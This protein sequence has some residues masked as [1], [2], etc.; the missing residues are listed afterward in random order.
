MAPVDPA[1]AYLISA[2][3][4]VVLL[5]VISIFCGSK[6]GKN[7]KA[8]DQPV[9]AAAARPRPRARE[10]PPGARGVRRRGNR[11][12]IRDD[13]SDDDGDGRP[14]P[15][16]DE[17]IEEEFGESGKIGAKKLR[18]LQDKAEKKRQREIELQER[19]E[20]K[21]R[22]QKL[23]AQRKKEEELQ[24]LEEEKKAEEERLRK[25]EQERQEHEEYLKYKEMFSVDEEGETD[26]TA[27]LSS[28]SLLQEFI[29]YIKQMK[30]VMLEDLATHFNIKTQDCIDRIQ[31]LQADGSLTGVVDDRGKFIYITTEELE[32]VAKFIKQ[33]GR[34]SISE[35]AESSNRLIN[36]NP[37]NADVHK[38][39]IVGDNESEIIEACG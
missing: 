10:G 13:E 16:D 39:F 36:L 33:H 5:A 30:V 28:Q 27:D 6:S 26:Q 15:V 14:P 4:I 37:D 2:A 18:K 12:Q 32:S 17:M 1:T 23:E 7:E 24:R 8:G 38:K 35:L 22:E 31:D 9:Q 34:I 3:V 11:M 25:E 21:E 20:K 19:E 29:N